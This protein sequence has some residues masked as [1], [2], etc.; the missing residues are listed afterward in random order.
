VIRHFDSKT[1]HSANVGIAQEGSFNGTVAHELEHIRNGQRAINMK[2]T[3][4]IDSVIVPSAD[5]DAGLT[6]V[7]A[8]LTRGVIP[9]T[10]ESFGGRLAW[11]A[12]QFQEMDC[13]KFTLHYLPTVPTTTA[14]A[15]ALCFTP[16]AGTSVLGNDLAELTALS[17]AKYQQTQVW[18]ATSLDIK[19]ADIIGGYMDDVTG[20]WRM[21]VQGFISVMAASSLAAGTIGN[22][23][24]EYE[25]DFFAPQITNEATASVTIDLALTAPTDPVGAGEQ[26]AEFR[27]VIAVTSSAGAASAGFPNFTAV[28]FTATEAELVDYLWVGAVVTYSTAAASN[29]WYSTAG[30]MVMAGAANDDIALS[31]GRAVYIRFWRLA[32]DP[33]SDSRIAA[34]FYGSGVDAAAASSPTAPEQVGGS[35]TLDSLIISTPTAH[36]LLFSQGMEPGASGAGTVWIACRGIQMATPTD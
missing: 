1:F 8:H 29:W 22:L 14:G 3:Q 9:V 28:G 30:Q 18:Q 17:T 5:A 24:L 12:E 25:Y 19:P 4:L 10:P 2:G 32:T 16:D 35:T 20:D 6:S 7:G 13:K 33:D 11:M 31:K 36:Q 23:F 26:M 27:P 21:A 34:T 15:I